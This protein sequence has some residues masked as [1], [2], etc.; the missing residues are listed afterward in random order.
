MSYKFEKLEVWTLSLEY[1]DI[2]YEVAGLL[3]ASG[4]V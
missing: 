1:G 2:I 3:P 4:A